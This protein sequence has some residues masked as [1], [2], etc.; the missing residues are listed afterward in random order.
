MDDHFVAELT[1]VFGLFDSEVSQFGDVRAFFTRQAL[2]ECAEVFH[3]ANDATVGLANF[4]S[5][6]QASTSRSRDPWIL[7]LWR[8]DFAFVVDIDLRAGHFGDAA[9]I[10]TARANECTDF[11]GCD[12][13]G[14][15]AWRVFAEILTAF[16]HVLGHDLYLHAV[17]AVLLD[18]FEGDVEGKASDLK[19][20]G[21]L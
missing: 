11:I 10:F 4:I 18:C 20:A 21:N 15:D 2:D 9:D 1:N 16:W 17:I 14:V 13:D 6:V 8:M 3:A 5:A 12:R 7:C 19:I